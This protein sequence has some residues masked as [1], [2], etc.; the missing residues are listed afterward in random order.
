VSSTGEWVSLV[1]A[2][3]DDG[4]FSYERGGIYPKEC[5]PPPADSPYTV[6]PFEPGEDVVQCPACRQRFA[7]TNG[8]S[9]EQ[10]RDEHYPANCPTAQHTKP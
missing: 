6:R 7:A 9:A 4:Q 2:L 3:S 5:P 8:E 1:T 10:C